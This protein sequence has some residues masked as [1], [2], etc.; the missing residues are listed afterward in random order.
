MSGFW[1]VSNFGYA[2]HKRLYNTYKNDSN[3]YF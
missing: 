2:K 1:S 3:R